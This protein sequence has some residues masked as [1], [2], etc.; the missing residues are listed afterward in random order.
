MNWYCILTKMAAVDP[1][2]GEQMSRGSC[3]LL[4]VKRNGIGHWI[5]GPTT[6]QPILEATVTHSN[7]KVDIEYAT[8]FHPAVPAALTELKTQFLLAYF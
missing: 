4:Y 5:T 3:A 6:L 1:S 7:K 8:A 2:V